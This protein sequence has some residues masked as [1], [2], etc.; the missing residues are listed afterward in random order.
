MIKYKKENRHWIK[1]KAF[2]CNNCGF[3]LELSPY[4]IQVAKDFACPCCTSK[5]SWKPLSHATPKELDNELYKKLLIANN[6][7]KYVGGRFKVAKD[8]KKFNEWLET[9]VK[10]VRP[11][12]Y[13]FLKGW[14]WDVE[15][16][17]D[18][19]YA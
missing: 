18:A 15:M 1:T 5:D 12:L 9:E 4:Y 19:D 13:P 7:L 6:R 8:Y 17:E 2:L 11:D 10:E 3:R 16:S 14:V